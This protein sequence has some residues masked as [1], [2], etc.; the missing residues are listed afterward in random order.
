M[1]P[2]TANNN[3][4]SIS[5]ASG[6]VVKV[7]KVLASGLLY[8]LTTLFGWLQLRSVLDLLGIKF[9]WYEVCLVNLP[10]SVPIVLTQVQLVFPHNFYPLTGD[11]VER[12]L[13]YF[14]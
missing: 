5:T 10:K 2:G 6:N 3:K 12:S 11:Q 8:V 14:F 1:I 9:P 13:L 7:F 4:D